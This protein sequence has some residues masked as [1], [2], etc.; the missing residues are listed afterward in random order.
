MTRDDVERI[1]ENVLRDLSI[2][3]NNGDFTDPNKRTVL[4]MYKG[5]EI[6]RASFDIVQ[7]DEYE[8]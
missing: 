3:V 4:L 6:D 1:V 5:K 7:T 8:G 2:H